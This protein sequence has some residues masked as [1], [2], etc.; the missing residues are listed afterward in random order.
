MGQSTQAKSMKKVDSARTSPSHTS[1]PRPMSLFVFSDIVGHHENLLDFFH[2]TCPSWVL[3]SIYCPAW[4]STPNLKNPL[5]FSFI[6]NSS[7]TPKLNGLLVFHWWSS[8]LNFLQNQS[9]QN[10]PIPFLSECFLVLRISFLSRNIRKTR[11]IDLVIYLK[12]LRP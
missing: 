12:V 6:G 1:W 3:Q 8:S 7:D 11:T 2:I 9:I 5:I 10:P 4:R